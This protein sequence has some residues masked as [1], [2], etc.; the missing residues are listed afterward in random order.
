MARPSRVACWFSAPSRSPT[1][2][3][4]GSRR[5]PI[6]SPPSRPARRR[7]RLEF[8]TWHRPACAACAR[9]GDDVQVTRTPAWAAATARPRR[10]AVV[11][12][13]ARRRTGGGRPKALAGLLLVRRPSGGCCSLGDQPSAH[14]PGCRSGVQQGGADRRLA[15]ASVGATDKPGGAGAQG[16]EVSGRVQWGSWQARAVPGPGSRRL[17]RWRHGW[18]GAATGP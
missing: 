12:C 13:P 9:L 1:T 15:D 10:P 16:R 3:I 2:R 7:Q 4:T 8:T 17:P 6:R 18:H 14:H 11:D 5:A